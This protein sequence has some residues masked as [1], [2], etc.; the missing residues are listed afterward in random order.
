MVKMYPLVDTR[1]ARSDTGRSAFCA[2]ELFN[3]EQKFRL[4]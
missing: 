3:I 2:S 4:A 1:I